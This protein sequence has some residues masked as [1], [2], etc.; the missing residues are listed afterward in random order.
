MHQ[1]RVDVGLGHQTRREVDD[2]SHHG[3]RQAE[4]RPDVASEDVPGIDADVQWEFQTCVEDGA[5]NQQ[6]PTLRI[7]DRLWRRGGEY[8]LGATTGDVR[9][10]QRDSV[11]GGVT[12][13][14]ADE[15]IE[16][17]EEFVVRH[18]VD[19]IVE[20]TDFDKADRHIAVLR[21]VDATENASQHRWRYAPID[22]THGSRFGHWSAVGD[23]CPSQQGALLLRGAMPI[24]GHQGS[25]CGAHQDL[26]RVGDGLHVGDG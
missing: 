12:L 3:V 18:G 4:W 7:L 20:V 5:G 26:A 17:G 1:H 24:A 11:G 22:A 2:I 9:R 15:G 6:Q 8:Q 23:G 16:L 13:R 14:R 25:R 21:F 19:E 10:Q